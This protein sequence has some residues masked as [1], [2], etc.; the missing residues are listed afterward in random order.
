MRFTIAV[1]RA[2]QCASFRQHYQTSLASAF[3][4]GA[5][6]VLMA[7]QACTSLDYE[8]ATLALPAEALHAIKT[9][10]PHCGLSVYRFN[11]KR[12]LKLTPPRS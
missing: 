1:A 12:G 4:R 7:Q 9:S 5:A 3:Y 11:R 8:D 2:T 10:F 6:A